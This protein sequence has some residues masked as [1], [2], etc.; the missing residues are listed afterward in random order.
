[1]RV[2]EPM[3]G[4]PDMGPQ[5]QLRK[6]RKREEFGEGPGHPFHGNQYT[7]SMGSNAAAFSSIGG[8]VRIASPSE[9]SQIRNEVISMGEKMPTDWHEDTGVVLTIA[10]LDEGPN[11]L[12]ARDASG[13]IAG[14]LSFDDNNVKDWGNAVY[15]SFLGTTG[16]DRKSTRLNS[17]HVS[18]FRMPSSA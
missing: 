16:I 11:V 12:V 13:A 3:P 15:I 7:G 18:E 14:A 9:R 17:S 4:G 2:L 10:A 1:M 6:A 8:T 5:P